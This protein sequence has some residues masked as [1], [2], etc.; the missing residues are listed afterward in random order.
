MPSALGLGLGLPLAPAPP[1]G[2]GGGGVFDLLPYSPTLILTARA[3]LTYAPPPAV[4][5]WADQSGNARDWTS[6]G[7]PVEVAGPAVQFAD[8]VPQYFSRVAAMSDLLSA[9]AYSIYCV[10][11]IN[12]IA[13]YVVPGGYFDN[14]PI[15]ADS[16]EYFWFG[17]FAP[18]G[19]NQAAVSHYSG[20]YSTPA[21]VNVDLGTRLLLA[22]RFGAGA[23]AISRDGG[24]ET[25]Q[26][27]GN[28]TLNAPQIGRSGGPSGNGL[29]ADIH[30][31]V[32]FD[33]RKS[34]ADHAAI[35]AGMMS[36]WGI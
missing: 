26:A 15:L 16:G 24:A 35:V 19:V 5:I 22:V 3:G 33:T 11:T 20:G 13:P 32:T 12:A 31:L 2:G 30:E 14:P 1:A 36:E 9:S 18:G 7:D 27:A 29:E 10:L 25:T 4:R 21:A 23:L 8:A 6:T 28:P 17:T 34:N